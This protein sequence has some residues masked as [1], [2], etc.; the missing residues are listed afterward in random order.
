VWVE[1][2][3]TQINARPGTRTAFLVLRDP[4]VDMSLSVTCSPQ[5]LQ[6]SPVPLT[7]GSRVVMF[8]KLS[9]YT[10][11]GSVSLR[12]TEIRAV[13]IGELL[14]RIER[15]RALLAAEGLFDPRPDHRP[16]KCRRARCP[17]RGAA[18]LAG[19]PVRDS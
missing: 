18:P 15:L 14:A 17:Q 16:S 6:N 10:G 3:I 9:F 8:G 5:L 4:S 1:G 12:V 7:E 2:Q 19:R 11:R 13:G